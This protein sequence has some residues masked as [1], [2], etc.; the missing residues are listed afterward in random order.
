MSESAE[1]VIRH[2]M[3]P[4]LDPLLNDEMARIVVKGILRRRAAEWAATIASGAEKVADLED[5]AGDVVLIIVN[6]ESPA[7][8]RVGWLGRA[9]MNWQATRALFIYDVSVTTVGQ[10]LQEAQTIQ[11]ASFAPLAIQAPDALFPASGTDRSVLYG[12]NIFSAPWLT[13]RAEIWLGQGTWRII[14]LEFES[15]SVTV[16]VHRD[17]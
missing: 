8:V 10:N 13:D 6:D 2:T 15:G 9:W 16:E 3:S 17:A 7:A 4:E 11:E 12:V 14:F 1:L 5:V